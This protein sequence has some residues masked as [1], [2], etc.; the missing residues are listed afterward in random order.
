MLEKISQTT[1]FI[2]Q[3]TRFTPDAAIVLRSGL[4]GLVNEIETQHTLEYTDIPNFPVST[5]KGHTGRLIFGVLGGKKVVAMQGRFHFYEGYTMQEV[6]FPIRVFKSLGIELLILSNASGGMNP[7]FRVG[8]MVFLRDH[9]NLMPSN[10]LLGKNHDELGPR[11]PEMGEPYDLSLVKMASEIAEEK[12]FRAHS[13]V[14]AGVPGPCF[15]TPAEYR[16][17]RT[18]GADLVGMSTVPEVIVARHAGLTC[19]AVSVVTD[20]GGFEPVEKVSHE[21]VLKVAKSAE[22]RVTEVV[23]GLLSRWNAK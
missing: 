21:E 8:D 5:V 22:G 17:L 16:Y 1:A 3:Q 23:K 4:G 11:F 13:G 2:T 20:L 9:I 6:T 12:K 19:F 15:E 14:Y 18:I 7:G 10:P